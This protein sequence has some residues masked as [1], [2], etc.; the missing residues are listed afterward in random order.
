MSHYPNPADLYPGAAAHI[1]SQ[2]LTLARVWRIVERGG[3]TRVWCVVWAGDA[4][5][6]EPRILPADHVWLS[7]NPKEPPALPRWASTP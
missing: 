5:D 4:C 1:Y 2:P 3:I 7:D 6:P